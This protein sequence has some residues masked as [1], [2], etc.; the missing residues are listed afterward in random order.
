VLTAKNLREARRGTLW[1]GYLKLFPIFIFLV[2]GMIAV[3]LKQQGVAG[4]ADKVRPD[5]AFPRL[6][7]YLLPEGQEGIRGLVL[8]G[9]LAALMSSLASLFNSTAT[10]FTVDFYKRLRPQAGEAHLVKGRST[11]ICSWSS[12]CWRRRSPLSSC[13]ASSRGASRR[14]RD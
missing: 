13:S 12:R 5:E 4:F 14:C 3:A 2:P 6:V 10:L 8:A 9:M 11:A 7:S 1:A